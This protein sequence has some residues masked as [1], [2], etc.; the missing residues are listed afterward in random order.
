MAA[1]ALFVRYFALDLTKESKVRLG[2]T[3]KLAIA[4]PLRPL[5]QKY[6]ESRQLLRMGGTAKRA[7]A[8]EIG[9]GSGSGI[10]ILFD[11]FKVSEVD[12]FDIDFDMLKRSK[13]KHQQ[14]SVPIHLW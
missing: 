7:K 4:N 11:I 8:L 3:E 12:A 10:D 5:V 13:R 2:W 6:F 14:H 1:I 9:C